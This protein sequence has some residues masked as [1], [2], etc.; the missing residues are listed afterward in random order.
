MKRIVY[1]S[2]PD[3]YQ[4]ERIISVKLDRQR[5]GE[6]WLMIESCPSDFRA[7]A[8][9]WLEEHFNLGDW[10][11]IRRRGVTVVKNRMGDVGMAIYREGDSIPY[12]PGLGEMLA[13]A[14]SFRVKE[15]MMK[16]I[17]MV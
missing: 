12:N 9:E 15:E 8:R 17:G 5:K 13:L 6:M 7:A 4:N 1:F 14:D 11:T 2:L 16:E 10:C 3:S